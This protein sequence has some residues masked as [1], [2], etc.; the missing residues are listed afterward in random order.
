MSLLSC[1]LSRQL[2]R[3][4]STA[5][6]LIALSSASSSSNSRSSFATENSNRSLLISCAIGTGI[7]GFCYLRDRLRDDVPT[8]HAATA[9]VSRRSQFNFIA[10]V[11][12][13]TAKSL[14]YIEIQDTRKVDYYTGK[15]AT[16]SN[17]SGFIVD[18]DGLILTNAHVVVNKP[19][20]MVS[21]RLTDGRIFQGVVEAVDPVSD[22]ATVRIQCKK[23][24]ALKLGDSSSLRSGEF[25][26]AL[27]SPLG[28][29]QVR[30]ST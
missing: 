4:R 27:G 11:V 28:K 30:F 1:V 6:H 16:I 3:H 24:P 22:L 5:P 13:I 14:V 21:V 15:A 8:V 10:D 9:P 25:V 12:E 2:L 23:L 7:V 29:L 20:S 19:R 18:P 17:G 26:V